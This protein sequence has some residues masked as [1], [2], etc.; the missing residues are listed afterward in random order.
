MPEFQLG[1]CQ[2]YNNTDGAD[3]GKTYGGVTVAVEESSV[4]LN[5]DQDGETPV[6]EQIVGTT[7]TVTANL[8]EI[9]L[10]NLAFA[11]K[12]SVASNQVKIIPNVGTSLFSNSKEIVIKPYVNGV[13][14]T[15]QTKMILIPKAG[16]KATIDMSYN[17]SD[18]RAIALTLTGYPDSSLSGSP[19]AVFGASASA[20]VV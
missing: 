12:T 18:Q 2:I 10:A 4:V 15:D 9:T 3:L 5:T 16:I 7:V 17:A 11:L 14:T 6:D 19:C 1:P 20:S 13:V 8:A